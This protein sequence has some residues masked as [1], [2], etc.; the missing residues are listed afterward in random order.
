MSAPVELL[1][2]RFDMV[3]R[4][5]EITSRLQKFQQARMS[6]EMDAQRCEMAGGDHTSE[7][8]EARARAEAADEG[9]AACEA[10]IAK[11]EA[12][13]DETDREIAAQAGGRAS[14]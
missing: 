12:G 13:L 2:R 5:S 1:R 10:E 6:A 14:L 8:S 3:A 11:V 7:L 4:L 9:A